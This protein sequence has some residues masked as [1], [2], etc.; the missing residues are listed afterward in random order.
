MAVDELVP[1]DGLDGGQPSKMLCRHN[2]ALSFYRA[3]LSSV[4]VS[5]IQIC[6]SGPSRRAIKGWVEAMKYS[7]V[8]RRPP[9]F[10]GCG[11][12]VQWG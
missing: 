4:A 12:A 8:D 5:S 9:A 7:G 2:A 11:R 3:L 6:F 1:G 10:N